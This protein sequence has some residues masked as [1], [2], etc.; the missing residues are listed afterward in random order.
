MH[1]LL[2]RVEREETSRA[3]DGVLPPAGAHLRGEKAAEDDHRTA[4]ERQTPLRDPLVETRDA[5]RVAVEQVPAV[6]VGGR[7]DAVDRRRR[8][9][10][11]ETLRVDVD[12][13]AVESDA[14]GTLHQDSRREEAERHLELTNALA[15]TCFAVAV[16]AGD[17]LSDLFQRRTAADLQGEVDDQRLRLLVADR[18]RVSAMVD[19]RKLSQESD[20]EEMHGLW[21]CVRIARPQARRRN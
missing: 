4:P 3:L 18:E 11:H 2:R 10:V 19:R 9:Q 15:S 12:D 7:V 6:Q 5:A 13:V 17:Q 20:L 8:H 14:V 16:A 1:H 21:T